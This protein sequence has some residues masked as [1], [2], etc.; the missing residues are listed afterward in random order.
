MH[1]RTMDFVALPLPRRTQ[2]AAADLAASH[3]ALGD[4]IL[5]IEGARKQSCVTSAGA[6]AVF[7]RFSGPRRR[8]DGR[9]PSPGAPHPLLSS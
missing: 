8:Q 9:T 4:P 1:A 6:V 3:R 7:V 2:Q 5:P